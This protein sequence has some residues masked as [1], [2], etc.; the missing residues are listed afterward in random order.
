M[1]DRSVTIAF[2]ESEL[3]ELRQEIQTVVEHDRSNLH[4]GPLPD[5]ALVSALLKLV[6]ASGGVDAR[7]VRD[8]NLPP[9]AAR[10]VVTQLV[11]DGVT[12]PQPVPAKVRKPKRRKRALPARVTPLAA[13]AASTR[14]RGDDDAAAVPLGAVAGGRS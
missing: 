11:R 1:I 10:V 12:F 13:V 7:H 6:R 2:T 14:D 8:L 5:A 9:W 3:H 4:R